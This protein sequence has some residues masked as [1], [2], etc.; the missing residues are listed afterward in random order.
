ME[1]ITLNL[2][3]LITATPLPFNDIQKQRLLD[4]KQPPFRITKLNTFHHS[5]FAWI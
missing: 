5:A 1:L 2:M 4:I 3:L